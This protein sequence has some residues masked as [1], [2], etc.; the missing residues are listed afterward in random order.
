MNKLRY[1]DVASDV[2][3]IG[4]HDDDDDNDDCTN[5]EGCIMIVVTV[6]NAMTCEERC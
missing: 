3:E 1:D 2:D 5:Y 6:I 4:D